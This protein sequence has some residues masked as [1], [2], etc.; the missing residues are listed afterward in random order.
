MPIKYP[1]NNTDMALNG[2]YL[3]LHEVCAKSY[4]TS[5]SAEQSTKSHYKL[6][7]S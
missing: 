2:V 5:G 1:S 3:P 6:K 7:H 4:P